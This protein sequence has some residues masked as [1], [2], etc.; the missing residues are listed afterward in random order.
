[1]I[2]TR[3]ANR[4]AEETSTPWALRGWRLSWRIAGLSAQAARTLSWCPP[5]GRERPCLKAQAT[6]RKPWQAR[7]VEVPSITAHEPSSGNASATSISG[8]RMRF[9]R[10][11]L[12]ASDPHLSLALY[13]DAPPLSPCRARRRSSF[14]QGQVNH[15]GRVQAKPVGEFWVANSPHTALRGTRAATLSGSPSASE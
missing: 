10:S 5:R 1:M 8:G 12:R 7:R 15:S 9:G 4:W 11:A 13:A 14:R 6:A 2:T 3:P